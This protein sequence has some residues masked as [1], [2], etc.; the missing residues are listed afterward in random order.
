MKTCSKLFIGLAAV[1]LL[2]ACNR[3]PDRDGIYIAHI[4]G[5]YSAADDTLIVEGAFVTKRTG[6]Q[7]LRNGRLLPKQ[8]KTLTLH[9]G[10]EDFPVM[11]F[12]ADRIII[13]QTI[14]HKQP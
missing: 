7:K 8:Y 11:L 13:G 12:K 6:F 3:K 9:T 10:S 14:Y 4:R 2:T 5:E 1:T